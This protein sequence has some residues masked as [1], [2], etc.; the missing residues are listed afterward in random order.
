MRQVGVGCGESWLGADPM[1]GNVGFCSSRKCGPRGN[2]GHGMVLRSWASSV[3]D[4]GL[5]ERVSIVVTDN[6]WG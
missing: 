6:R 3:T 5:G 2:V 4:R 1:F